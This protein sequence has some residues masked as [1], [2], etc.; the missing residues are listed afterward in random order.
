MGIALLFLLDNTVLKNLSRGQAIN[1]ASWK[2][3]LVQKVAELLPIHKLC[4]GQDASGAHGSSLCMS[5]FHGSGS[6]GKSV[7]CAQS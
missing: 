7:L 6:Q 4:E 5:F 1:K 3:H 2:Y